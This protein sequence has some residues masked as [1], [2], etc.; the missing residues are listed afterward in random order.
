MNKSKK[1][2][3]ISLAVS[4]PSTIKNFKDIKKPTIVIIPI[5]IIYLT[6]SRV[7]LSLSFFGYNIPAIKLPLNV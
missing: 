1:R 6:E 4:S 5:I 3:I 2:S 7:N